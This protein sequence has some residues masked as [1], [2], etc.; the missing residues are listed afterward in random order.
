MRSE[1]SVNKVA[2]VRPPFIEVHRAHTVIW[3]TVKGKTNWLAIKFWTS[4]TSR[5]GE[6]T[7]KTYLQT[8]AVVNSE[9]SD[10]MIKDQPNVHATGANRMHVS[11]L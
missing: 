8:G 4:N 2:K 10:P 11:A 3:K 7:P 9:V 6:T 5:P 1:T